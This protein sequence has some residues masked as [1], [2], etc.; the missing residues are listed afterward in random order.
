MTLIFLEDASQLNQRFQQMK[1]A[2]LGRLTASIAHE[3]RNP[4]AAIQHAS[5]LLG[6]S[7]EDPADQKLTRI[8]SMQT[9]RLNSVVKNVLH[10]SRKQRNLPD[11]IQLNDWLQTF[12]NEFFPTHSMKEEQ[13]E[14]NI[15]PKNLT[16]TFD[17]E[18]LHQIFWNLCSN[19]I[20]HS[21]TSSR[22]LLINIHGRISEA[23]QQPIIDIT[24]NGQGVDETIAPHIFEPFYTT[25]TEG[26]GLGLYIIKE[27]VENNRA[28]IELVNQH[29]KNNCFRIHFMQ[30]DTKLE[31]H[32][33]QQE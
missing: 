25:S 6:E 28:K 18:Q 21:S 22:Q 13:I 29:G 12:K 2:S 26:T 32:L 1:L 15:T 24:D 5:Q 8:I 27:I 17:S 3:I 9:Q 23:D 11:T 14:I 19:S 16:I 30:A 10:L 33:K 4:L 20:N 31:N 7:I